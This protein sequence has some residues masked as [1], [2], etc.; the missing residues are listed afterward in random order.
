MNTQ[1]LLTARINALAEAVGAIPLGVVVSMG[2]AD[3]LPRAAV[4]LDAWLSRDLTHAEH[5]DLHEV[6]EELG[7]AIHDFDQAQAAKEKN[8]E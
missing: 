5:V 4:L 7:I 2:A 6:A 1:D 3:H 8:H